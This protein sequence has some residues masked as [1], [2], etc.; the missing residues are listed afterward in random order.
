MKAAVTLIGGRNLAS[1]STDGGRVALPSTSGLRSWDI[2]TGR[3]VNAGSP[4]FILSPDQTRV[5]RTSAYEMP[6]LAELEGD[7]PAR[8]LRVDKTNGEVCSECF[9]HD[10]RLIATS[11]PNG[12]IQIWDA[13]SAKQ[14]VRFTVPAGSDKPRLAFSP[15][16]RRLFTRVTDVRAWDLRKGNAIGNP[17]TGE[18]KGWSFNASGSRI[19]VVTDES[20]SVLDTGT[21]APVWPPL[22]LKDQPKHRIS[23][24]VPAFSPNG[25]LLATYARYANVAGCQLWDAETGVPLLDPIRP[26]PGWLF[27]E[28]EFSA[29]SARL[30]LGGSAEGK[31]FALI[32]DTST[33]EELWRE[34]FVAKD[35]TSN[36][37]T[38]D[39]CQLIVGSNQTRVWDMAPPGKAPAF[40]ADAAEAASGLRLTDAGAL[41]PLANPATEWDRVRA[42][43]AGLAAANRWAQIGRWFFAESSQRPRSPYAV[44]DE[45]KAADSAPLFS[46]VQAKSPAR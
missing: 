25:R 46:P 4:D 43:F 45:L 18:W 44:F 3:D 12:S 2:S 13:E 8:E 5:L 6:A 33:G 20:L 16:G 30:V 32:I 35:V 10:G 26:P 34:E 31:G 40:L 38:P 7:K 9:S 28:M 11:C 15:D 41:E 29:D 19:A 17:I 24:E 36:H 21:G 37:F 22:L 1:F 14:I 23:A 42:Q 27:T 39:G